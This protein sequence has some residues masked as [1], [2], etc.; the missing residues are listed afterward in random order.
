[1]M[2]FNYDCEG[3]SSLGSGKKKV[4]TAS[5]NLLTSWASIEPIVAVIGQY[6]DYCLWT[7]PYGDWYV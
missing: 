6:T 5:R 1:M 2:R 4:S 3:C 7:G